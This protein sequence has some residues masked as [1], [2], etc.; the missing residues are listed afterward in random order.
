MRRLLLSLA[1]ALATVPPAFP[2]LP[3]R[4]PTGKLIVKL[5]SLPLPSVVADVADQLSLQVIKSSPKSPYLLAN[6]ARGGIPEIPANLRMC[7]EYVEPEVRMFAIGA[8]PVGRPK[9]PSSVGKPA[10]SD[11]E[12]SEKLQELGS[13]PN[14]PMFPRQWDM[15]DTGYGIGLPT[16]RRRATGLGVVVAIIDTGVRQT[17]PDLAATSFLPGYNAIRP[18]ALP[19]DDNGHGSHVCGTIAQSTDNRVGVAGIAPAARILPI[20]VLDSHGTGT[21][22]TI[23]VGIRWATEHG[24]N[25]INMS[26]GGVS[27]QTLKDAVQFASGRG[28]TLCCAAGNRGT[29]GLLYPAAYPETISVGAIEWTGQRASFS[30]YGPALTLVAPGVDILQNTFDPRDGHAYYGTWSGTSMAC[31]HVTGAVALLLQLNPGMTPAD[32]KARLTGTARDL[33]V[34]GKDVYY[35]AG[36]LDLKAALLASPVAPPPAP[37]PLPAPGPTPVPIPPPVPVPDPVP[38]PGTEIFRQVLTLFNAE[39][40]RNGVAP[41]SLEPRL[42]AAAAAHCREMALTGILSHTGANGSN[43]GQRITLAGYPW[44]TWGEIVAWGQQDAQAV[45]TAWINSPGHHAIMISASYTEIGVAMERS[46]GG[47]PFWCVDFGRR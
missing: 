29:N 47:S 12:R 34:P 38:N 27:S 40:A 44:S 45:T 32:V 23:A 28:V 16:A 25:V 46:G 1:A 24:A 9:G 36:L 4:L 2:D 43:P 21:N 39:R 17:L 42:A 6:R 20:K 11:S 18:D 19:R 33:G 31:P 41:V 22:Y 26:L 10:R 14:D 37:G 5:R 30:Q 3:A 15:Q 35:G 8:V 13:V 7:V